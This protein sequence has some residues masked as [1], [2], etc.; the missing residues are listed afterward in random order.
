MR[1][2]YINDFWAEESCFQGLYI[3]QIICKNW[4][5]FWFQNHLHQF[6][7]IRCKLDLKLSDLYFSIINLMRFALISD[8]LIK[9]IIIKIFKRSV[10]FILFYFFRCLEFDFEFLDMIFLIH[11]NYLWEWLLILRFSWFTIGTRSD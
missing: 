11:L 1:M 9:T 8:F 6:R 7:T 10:Y 4:P 2:W 3:L 5:F